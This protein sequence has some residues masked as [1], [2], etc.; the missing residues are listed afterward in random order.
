MVKNI[1]SLAG[2]WPYQKQRTKLL[3]LSLVTL[4]TCSIMAPQGLVDC[5]MSK[6]KD[7]SVNMN[8][9]SRYYK[10]VKNVSS[11]CGQWP[12]QRQRTRLLCLSWVTL[13]IF[14][15]IIPQMT[16]FVTCDGNIQCIFTTSAASALI[17]LT[18]VKLYTCFFNRY[19]MKTLID[20]LLEEWNRINNPEECKIL[21]KYAENTRLLSFGYAF[22]YFSTTVMFMSVSF[23][24]PLLDIVLPLNNSRPLLPPHPAYYFVDEETYFYYIYWHAV[25]GWEI[26]VIGIVSHDCLLLMYIEHICCI[27]TIVGFRFEQLIT[28][29]DTNPEK[30]LHPYPNV[31]YRQQVAFSVNTHQEALK[32]AELIEDT[33]SLSLGIQVALSTVTISITLLQIAQDT[34]D[35]LIVTRY[36]VYVAA[37][38]IH[39]F[40]LSF[41]GQRLIDH[42]LQMRNKI[43]NSFWYQTSPKLQKI[44]LFIMRKSLQPISLS[45]GKIFIFSMES[46]T[47]IVQTSMSY[48]TVLATVE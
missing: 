1:T 32:F 10:T 33:F 15:V 27:F 18:L 36:V 17:I 22:Y 20:K 26:A 47:S 38:L 42:S 12:Y 3:C 6:T 19:K 11:L 4:S 34:A 21:K 44:L 9:T 2:Q 23:I 40:C 37:Q 41:E 46:F 48:F 31:K 8:V 45:A 5:A 7:S 13:S 39:L 35:L 14:S 16:K 29:K 43:Y 24:P 25:L 28:H 30:N